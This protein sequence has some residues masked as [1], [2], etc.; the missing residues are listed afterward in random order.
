MTFR[1]EVTA[2]YPKGISHEEIVQT[3]SSL[4]YPL[5]LAIEMLVKAGFTDIVKSVREVHQN[6]PA[7]MPVSRPS[8]ADIL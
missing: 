3:H 5:D 2:Q 6:R 4:A 8:D 1:I 7:P